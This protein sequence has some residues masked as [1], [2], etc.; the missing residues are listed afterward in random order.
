MN[1]IPQETGQ[2]GDHRL[3]FANARV[4]HIALQGVIDAPNYA[5]ATPFEVAVPLVDLLRAPAGPR[6]RQLLL[7]DGFDVIEL[8]DGFAFGR[9]SK[10][11]YCGYVPENA[12]CEPTKVTHWLA[13][14]ASH[15]YSEPR[16]DAPQSV[17]ISFGS[18]LCV[19]GQSGKF[20]ETPHGFVPTGHIQ[21]LGRWYGDPVEVAGLFLGVPYLWGGNSHAGVDCSGLVQ[22]SLLACGRACP[23]DSDLQQGLGQEI[24]PDAALERG[25]LL[26][27]KGHVAMMVDAEVMIHATGAFMATVI[28]PAAEAIARIRAQTGGDVIARRRLG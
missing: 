5:D 12:L 11:G 4:A 18:R 9:S 3:T 27:W 20:S 10:D 17:G 22:M 15:L 28:E 7:G 8:R 14:P 21:T 1:D 19:L 13:A 26:F 23:G 2:H 16:A 24:A 6:E 25:D